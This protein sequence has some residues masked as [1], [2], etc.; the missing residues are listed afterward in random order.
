[1][2]KNP[3]Q[4]IMNPE[5]IVY[6]GGSNSLQTIGTAQLITLVTGG[7]QGEIYPIHRQEKT[8]LGL[9]A[10]PA[11]SSLD[12]P[13]DLAIIVI[14]RKAIP[15]VLKECGEAGIHH[16]IIITAGYGEIGQKGARLQQELLEIAQKYNIRFL[17]PNCIGI[18]NAPLG[19]NTTWFPNKYRAGKVGIISQ[20]GSY[21]TQTLTYFEKL[22][23]GLSQAISV[24][25]Q[26][27]IDMVDCLEYLGEDE[28][29]RAIALYIEGIKRPMAFL[30]AA[31][32][33]TARK[34]VVAVYVGGSE[35]GAR[36]CSSHTASMAGPDE[37]YRGFFHQAGILRASNITDLFDWS[38][39]LAQQPLPS[40]KNIAIVTNSGGPGSSMA[41]EANHR[42]LNVPLL[43]P[44]VQD[45]IKA[46]TPLTASAINPVD[47]TMNY[48]VDL[49]YKK[50]PQLLLNLRNIDGLLFYGIFGTIHFQD[51]IA[52]TGSS[53]DNM[54]S[55]M[56]Q[57]LEKT[58]NEFVKLP[59]KFKKPILCA[60]F[61]GREDDAVTRIQD[62][63]IPVYPTPERAAG[64]MAALWEYAKIKDR[65]RH[66]S[67]EGE[68]NGHN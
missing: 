16:A 65:N 9:K 10:Y 26:A 55:L 2:P 22:G 19:L 64:A 49:I 30:Q 3:L 32:K 37:I 57:L 6:L 21:V 31:R 51:K 24:G 40:G 62:G 58:C 25:N 1:M 34:P 66:E 8:V 23:L 60:C 14:P 28:Q 42:G 44:A 38:L 33:I 54:L 68:I 18:V 56:K 27:D 63:G 67:S 36:A 29:T 5:S 13:A 35:A 4:T 15:G 41:D 47:I 11:V 53:D 46:I 12:K 7:Y 17:G 39:A 20:S 43:S 45:E 59:E 61:S 52:C 48:D 50:L